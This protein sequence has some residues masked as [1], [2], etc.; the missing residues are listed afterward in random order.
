MRP[1]RI[2]L[3]PCDR[4]LSTRRGYHCADE[5]WRGEVLLSEMTLRCTTLGCD[6]LGG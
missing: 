4:L 1:T 5:E 6:C 2:L 3:Q